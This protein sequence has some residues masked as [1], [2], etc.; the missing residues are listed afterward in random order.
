MD[1]NYQFPISAAVWLWISLT[2]WGIQSILILHASQRKDSV[3]YHLWRNG[4]ESSRLAL[5]WLPGL[6]LCLWWYS[7][8]GMYTRQL[9]A[10]DPF[11]HLLVLCFASICS[12]LEG[13]PQP[14]EMVTVNS[15]RHS[16]DRML[17]KAFSER[18]R[19]SSGLS[20]ISFWLEGRVGLSLLNLAVFISSQLYWIDPVRDG[21]RRKLD[22]GT[23]AFSVGVYSY[24]A[25]RLGDWLYL[26]MV[27][28]CVG[29][30]LVARRANVGG[31]S[32]YWHYS[33][34]VIGFFS[35]LYL[36]S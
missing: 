9:Q 30:Y 15:P 17:P 31:K 16:M 10:S 36:I 19:A 25:W 14:T 22:I 21:F 28:L 34:H 7:Q 27:T 33:M 3:S 6:S 35:N 23:S 13:P 11:K 2:L 8:A 26:L 29:L 20:L 18:L 32:S 12:V 5:C 4:F 1:L 24:V